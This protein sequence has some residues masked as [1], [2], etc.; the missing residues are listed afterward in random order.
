MTPHRSLCTLRT[1]E[2]KE[3]GVLGRA[4]TRIES[5]LLVQTSIERDGSSFRWILALPDAFTSSGGGLGC[6]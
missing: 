2:S 6:Y 3:P 4:H 1:L 5:V